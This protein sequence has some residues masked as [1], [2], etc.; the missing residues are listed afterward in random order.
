MTNP[1][2]DETGTFVVLINDEGQHSLWPSFAQVPAGWRVV[3]GEAGRQ[4][5]L[6]YVERN[7]TD[8]RPASL[9]NGEA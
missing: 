9:V 5:C 6:D 7:W 2:E 3:H 8:M 1:F 4:E